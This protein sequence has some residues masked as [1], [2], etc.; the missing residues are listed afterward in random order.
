MFDTVLGG[1]TLV[2]H[3]SDDGQAM[4]KPPTVGAIKYASPEPATSHGSRLI[5]HNP[6]SCYPR[7]HTCHAVSLP[8]NAEAEIMIVQ[9]KSPAGESSKNG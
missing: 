1:G 6:K 8:R 7:R 4:R 5:L 3:K 2:P 9:P